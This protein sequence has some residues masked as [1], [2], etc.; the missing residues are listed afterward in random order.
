[1]WGGVFGFLLNSEE[2]GVEARLTASA[3]SLEGR[4]SKKTRTAKRH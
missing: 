1:M 4:T 2:A 3:F